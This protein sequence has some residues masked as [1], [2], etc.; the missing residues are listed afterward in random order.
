MR[1]IVIFT[2]VLTFMFVAM[3]GA[4]TDQKKE[5]A[6][7]SPD[8]DKWA[9]T[10][11]KKVNN[12]AKE[13]RS[14]QV[15]KATTVAGVRGSEAEDNLVKQ[16]YYRGGGNYP[17]R[18]ELKNAI[19]ILQNSI[20]AAPNDPSVPESKFFIAQCQQQLGDANDAVDTYREI[21]K[22]FPDSP[23]AANAKEELKKLPQ[24]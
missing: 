23:F 18:L 8:N 10:V 17:S 24:K 20:K 2:F 12:V 13:K 3:L 5:P 21:I 1:H 6:K 9:N 16:L 7:T 14:F 11:W 15:E 22:Y 4:Q 19:D